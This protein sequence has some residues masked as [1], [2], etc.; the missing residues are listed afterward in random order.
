MQNASSRHLITIC[1][2][3]QKVHVLG[4][5]YGVPIFYVLNELY[6]VGQYYTYDQYKLLWQTRKMFAHSVAVVNVDWC[7]EIQER[8]IVEAFDKWNKE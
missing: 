4:V 1:S 8:Y 7:P 2:T 6:P 3:A 5:E